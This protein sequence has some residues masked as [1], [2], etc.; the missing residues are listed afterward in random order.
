MR[1]SR[2]SSTWRLIAFHLDD[3]LKTLRERN[4]TPLDPIATA[5]VRG[6]I[7]AIKELLALPER[8]E[9]VV[10]EPPGEDD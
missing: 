8:V 5:T 2:D 4:D 7:K 6:E 1:I 9:Q 3:R 10:Q